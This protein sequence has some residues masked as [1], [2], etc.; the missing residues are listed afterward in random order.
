MKFKI[1][2]FVFHDRHKQRPC[3]Q[4]SKTSK[5]T[6]RNNHRT[7]TRLTQAESF[8]LHPVF[9]SSSGLKNLFSATNRQLEVVSNFVQVAP[10]AMV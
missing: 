4:V 2:R 7:L 3:G 5:T 8:D 10:L 6:S 9:A 1:S